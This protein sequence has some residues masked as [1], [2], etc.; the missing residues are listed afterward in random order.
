M[1]TLAPRPPAPLAADL[2]EVLRRADARR[3]LGP[4]GRGALV[5]GVVLV[6]GALAW[7]LWQLDGV[8]EAVQQVLPLQVQWIAPPAPQPSPP[9][10]PA[11]RQPQPAPR[12]V[13]V[14]TAAPTPA[15]APQQA[16]TPAPVAVSAEP[17]PIAPVSA[18]VAAPPAPPPPAAPVQIPATA[19]RYLV[20]P[21]QVYPL[22]SRRL[23]EQG[24]VVLRLVVDAQGLPQQV[25]VHRSSGFARL[26][27]QALQAMRAARFAPH[28]VNGA[29]VP[30]TALAPLAYEID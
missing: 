21:A 15:P 18:P 6:H 2:H 26:D 17:A 11:P 3:D 1:T 29:A 22:A 14:V 27:E 9:P 24:T 12:P 5:A 10:P 23:R 16:V 25:S 19:L 4:A 13:P 20:P 7:G 8:R 28:T 30:W